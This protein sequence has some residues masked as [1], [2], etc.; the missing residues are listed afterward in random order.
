MN[1]AG[2]RGWLGPSAIGTFT[3]QW[4]L[5]AQSGDASPAGCLLWFN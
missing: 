4:L 3:L 2:N 5:E 1:L